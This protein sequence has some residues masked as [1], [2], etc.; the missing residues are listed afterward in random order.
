MSLQVNQ[1]K[2]W[3]KLLFT[4][5]HLTQKEI[6]IK[7]GVTEKTVSK[8]KQ[9]ENWDAL[10]ANLITTQETEYRRI[11]QQIIN[12]NNAIENREENPGIPDSK[13]ADILVKLSAAKKNMET[14][15]GI[16]TV[17][18]VFR[19]FLDFLRTRELPK[20]QE[21]AAYMD[22]YIKHKLSRL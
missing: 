7:V 6:A 12:L 19:D 15:I 20:A 2:E 9:K 22:N 14:E 21:F 18:D 13:E 8:W 11:L 16:D 4:R 17:V 1:K 5:E 3:A 10:K